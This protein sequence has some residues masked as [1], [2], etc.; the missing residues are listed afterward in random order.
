MVQV[1]TD[2][3]GFRCQC[4]LQC[5]RVLQQYSFLNENSSVTKVQCGVKPLEL[6]VTD[7][8]VA[9]PWQCSGRMCCV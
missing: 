3:C 7:A 2:E 6:R 1:C 9:V 4:R 8:A 5:C